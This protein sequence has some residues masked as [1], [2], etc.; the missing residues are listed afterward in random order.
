MYEYSTI[1][2]PGK[3]DGLLTCAG[4]S[5]VK[6]S[7]YAHQVT[8]AALYTLIKHRCIHETVRVF[9]LQ[10]MAYEY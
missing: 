3:A 10:C 8:L 7:R 9:Y 6:R 4:M 5:G 2:T 1:T